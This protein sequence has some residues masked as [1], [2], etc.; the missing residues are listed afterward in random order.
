[1]RL[2]PVHVIDLTADDDDQSRFIVH[3]HH[4]CAVV[5]ASGEVDIATSPQMSEAQRSAL[6]YSP[7]VVID[8]TNVT[9]MDSGG[10]NVLAS[11]WQLARERGGDIALVSP[12][13]AVCDALRIT[14]LHRLFTISDSVAAAITAVAH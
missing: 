13:E 8:L 10:L 1:M 11:G 7:R 6:D 2:S 14:G 4:G 5:E 3:R 12:A 9:F